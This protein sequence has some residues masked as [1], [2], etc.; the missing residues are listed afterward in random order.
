M[1]ISERIRNPKYL[2]KISDVESTADMIKDGMVVAVS[3]FTP[4]GCPKLVLKELA[5]QIANGRPHIK[6]DLLSGASTGP[7]I[8]EALSSLGVIRKRYPYITSTGMRSAINSGSTLYADGHLG[9]MAEKTR[10]GCFGH[11]DLAIVEACLIDEEGS[12]I[13]TTALGSVNTFV[14]EADAVIVELN[15]NQPLDL[16]GLHDIYD[17][18]DPPEREPI[19]LTRVDQRIGRISIP[20]DPEKIIA[21]VPS[22][23]P[24]KPRSFTATDENSH[25]IAAQIIKLLES[26]RDAG[27]LSAHSVPLQSGVGSVANAVLSGLAESN[28]SGLTFFSEVMQDAILDLF[29]AN[30]ADFCSATSLSLSEDGMKKL[31]KNFDKYK[32]KILLRNAEVSNNPEVIRRLGVIAMNT[33][34]EVDIY[35]N[36]NSTHMM[37]TNIYNGIGGSSD[38][39][40]GSALTIF[41]TNS[42]AKGGAIS[43]IVP[44]VSHVDHTEHDVDIIVTEQ[45]LADLRGLSPKERVPLIINNCAHPSYRALLLEYYNEALSV[46]GH[47]QTPHVLGKAF[48][49]HEKFI[50]TGSMK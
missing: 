33:A 18:K 6:I 50:E 34:V 32:D 35:G 15:M 46:S 1:S 2:G 25:A 49:F 16:V 21:I 43:S 44:M 41:M 3:G 42:T 20:C 37:G 4:S 7:E 48:S 9:S 22:N 26:E 19:P 24:E 13:P 28:F 14:R 45:G 10:Y 23:A 8:D 17:P 12:I 47:C 11:I 38:F 31:F 29:D 5:N 30:K 40:R 39:A 36:V 27:R